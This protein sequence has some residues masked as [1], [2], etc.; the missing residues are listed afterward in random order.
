[1][2]D[3]VYQ[4]DSTKY[5]L[6]SFFILNQQGIVLRATDEGCA[7]LDRKSESVLNKPFSDLLAGNSKIHW[8]KNFT[9]LCIS[10]KLDT[11]P[12]SLDFMGQDELVNTFLCR[13]HSYDEPTN[14][15]KRILVNIIPM[16]KIKG[17]KVADHRI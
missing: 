12:K 1:N 15:L 16:H 10:E 8:A 11:M 7:L 4:L 17:L 6:N 3:T 2:H 5:L 13:I 14:S 9:S